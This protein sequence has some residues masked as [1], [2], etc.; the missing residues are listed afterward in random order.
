MNTDFAIQKA[1]GRDALAALLGV[2][3]ITT[4]QASW[5]PD[6]PPKHERYL[7]LARPKWFKD[8]DARQLA[9]A[10]P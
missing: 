1:G 5:V 6:L 9:E 8:W 7:R 3:P 4:Y 10:R 2:K